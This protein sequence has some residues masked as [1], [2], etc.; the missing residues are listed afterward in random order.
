MCLYLFPTELV[1]VLEQQEKTKEVFSI[2]FQELDS[3]K[4]DLELQR[5][6]LGL[7]SLLK[8][9]VRTLPSTI[10]DGLPLIMK[11]LVA[12]CEKDVK[13]RKEV[14]DEEG[15]EGESK[16]KGKGGDKEMD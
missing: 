1:T 12:I 9:D 2:W 11:K 7:S 10:K 13:L 16:A 15:G 8:L 6:I 5:S 14:D 4:K 3:F